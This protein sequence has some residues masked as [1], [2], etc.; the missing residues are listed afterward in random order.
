MRARSPPRRP[1]SSAAIR[2]PALL[3]TASISRGP[4][5]ATTRSPP[6]PPSGV[7]SRRTPRA[8]ARRGS[9]PG[10]HALAGSP[11]QPTARPAH[12]RQAADPARLGHARPVDLVR[13]GASGR[14]ADP[15]GGAADP[16]GRRAHVVVARP[17]QPHQQ[18]DRALPDHAPPATPRDPLRQLTVDDA[19]QRPLDVLPPARPLLRPPDVGKGG[20]PPRR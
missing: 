2:F 14:A 17:E 10:L 6:W 11:G 15:A 4:S 12:P 20:E 16:R 18:R 3:S 9:P 5:P 8:R 7:G 1:P 19:L 13:L